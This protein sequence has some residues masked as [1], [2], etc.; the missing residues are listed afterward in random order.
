MSEREQ[1]LK[2]ARIAID[3]GD[4]ELED[5][6][7]KK[8]DALDHPSNP[9]GFTLNSI[10]KGL[11]G[12]GDLVVNAP[13]NLINLGKM[14]AG[15]AAHELLGTN[16]LPNVSQPSNL[17]HGLFEK[18]QMIRPNF[19]PKS[20]EGRIADYTIQS[21][22]GGLLSPG[23]AAKNVISG[24]LGGL[25][26]GITTETT[27][28]PEAGI[29]ASLI[30]PGSQALIG[31][32]LKSMNRQHLTETGIR[33]SVADKLIEVSG[34]PKEV[35]INKLSNIKQYVPNSEP[36]TAQAL[37]NSGLAGLERTYKNMP[38]TIKNGESIPSAF[39]LHAA[40]QRQA[41]ASAM[42]KIAPIENGA[43]L[44]KNN[45][46]N[47]VNHQI[48]N[49]QNIADKITQQIGTNPS[50]I[51]LGQ[52]VAKTISENYKQ[53][54]QS[55][56]DAYDS[57][58]PGDNSLVKIPYKKLQGVIDEMYKIAPETV[59]PELLKVVSIAKNRGTEEGSILGDNGRP[60][61]TSSEV[62]L[63]HVYA[64][65]KMAGNIANKAFN[66]GDRTLESSA[67]QMKSILADVP[68]LAAKNGEIPQD[69]A[70]R[71]MTAVNLRKKQG[72]LFETGAT[73][74]LLRYNSDN[75]PMLEDNSIMANF[76]NGSP[77]SAKRFIAAIGDSKT[78]YQAGENYLAG[79]FTDSIYSPNGNLK[80]GFEDSGQK[81]IKNMKEV[82]PLFPELSK[83]IENALSAQGIAQAN[84]DSLIG[85]GARHFLNKNDADYAI[86]SLMKS[87]TKTSDVK[88]ILNQFTNENHLRDQLLGA[89]KD[90]NLDKTVQNR[91]YDIMGNKKWNQGAALSTLKDPKNIELF[92]DQLTRNEKVSLEKLT[93]DLERVQFSKDAN[94]ASGSDT[95]QNAANLAIGKGIM[96]ALN[97]KTGGITGILQKIN[98]NIRQGQ[99]TSDISNM[100]LDPKYALDL[101]KNQSITG[102]Q[103]IK[104]KYPGIVGQ[105]AI[106]AN[107][108]DLRK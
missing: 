86:N 44:F 97:I 67:K 27:K 104:G 24:L 53:A 47:I 62:P 9:I 56:R 70:D 2:D 46:N 68:E 30:A 58:D 74:R 8:L 59:P 71:V 90:D 77:D 102:K 7:Y 16:N 98:D 76:L 91:S 107:N 81:F 1:L 84:K 17:I 85:G 21:I 43:E 20:P 61:I 64:L 29:L 13:E 39:E 6:V 34:L 18:A 40:E 105:A 25:A 41:Q 5:A 92:K 65:R 95:A 93:R 101:L 19:E 31:G 80:K 38:G 36:T 73:N 87:P 75:A 26:G 60:L 78:A 96:S 14:G 88:D 83:K 10:N 54:K 55:T 3:T 4:T 82:L 48:Q 79:K 100:L 22:T 66:A 94:R 103:Y 57:I 72:E 37:N 12:A 45:L 52:I 50:N 15:Y 63:S 108:N 23:N 11:A 51:G 89:L 99:Y 106:H 35:L 42:N 49:Q 28:S 69:M 33:N 32:G